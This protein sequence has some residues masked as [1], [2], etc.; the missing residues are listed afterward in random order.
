VTAYALAVST[1]LIAPGG[2]PVDPQGT[3]LGSIAFGMIY[4]VLF[5]TATLAIWLGLLLLVLTPL[6]FVGYHA[7]IRPFAWTLEQPH[8]E[9][10]IKVFSVLLLVVGFHFDLLST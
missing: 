5:L 3:A 6:L 10:H 2:D 4:A 1:T 9:Q 7:V 8:L